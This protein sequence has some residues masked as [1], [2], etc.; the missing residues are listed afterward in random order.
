MDDAAVGEAE[1]GEV[2]V[3][4]VHRHRGGVEEYLGAELPD[5]TGEGAGAGRVEVAVEQAFAVVHECRPE[6]AT[7]QRPGELDAELRRRPAPPPAGPCRPPR[8]SPPHRRGAAARDSRP[9]G[10]ARPDRR[11][12][13]A[14]RGPARRAPPRWRAPGGRTG[15]P[16]R[17]CRQRSAAVAPAV[18]RSRA[19]VVPARRWAGRARRR[20]R[21]P[22][23]PRTA[24][25]GCTA[26][27]SPITVTACT[28]GRDQLSE[29]RRRHPA[30]DHDDPAGHAAST[31]VSSTAQA[32]NSGMPETGSSA[33]L[34]SRLTLASPP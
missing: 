30:A 20:R 12:G 6:A 3:F 32:L 19:R 2:V 21:G 25:H 29:P 11:P 7:G 13:P 5:G 34:V 9:A 14:R 27:S 16:R 8:R 18:P 17:C 23:P 28:A 15:A 31:R 26:G 24:A 4:G 33:S 10:A 1:A 22:R